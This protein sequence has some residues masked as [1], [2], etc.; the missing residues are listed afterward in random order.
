MASAAST[1]TLTVHLYL[2]PS[3]LNSIPN[4]TRLAPSAYRPRP[5]RAVAA[6]A[7]ATLREV[8][9]GRVPDHVIQR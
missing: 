1:A 9:A 2:L 4:T 6:A 8:C 3:T 7:A 5:L